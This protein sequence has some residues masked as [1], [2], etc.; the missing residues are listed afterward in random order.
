MPRSVRQLAPQGLEIRE[1]LLWL[2]KETH[3]VTKPKRSEYLSSFL[4]GLNKLL[5]LNYTISCSVA[6][7]NNIRLSVKF[8]LWLQNKN[9]NDNVQLREAVWNH[10][11][12]IC[13]SIEAFWKTNKFTKPS[14]IYR[15]IY[16][17]KDQIYYILYAI[18]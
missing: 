5:P 2:F 14:C 16:G 1:K 18:C 17:P 12:N 4:I 15:I 11:Q 6:L 7:I 3:D 10:T 13:A 9:Q 8:C